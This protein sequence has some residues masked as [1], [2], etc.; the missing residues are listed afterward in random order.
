MAL[1]GRSCSRPPSHAPG[2]SLLHTVA[3]R[4]DEPAIVRPPRRGLRPLASFRGVARLT[5]AP[6]IA[7]TRIE[8]AVPMAR[9]TIDHVPRG[10]VWQ[11]VEAH[12][13]PPGGLLRV[14][15]RRPVAAA[16]LGMTRRKPGPAALLIDVA[17]I[18][19][20]GRRDRPP[21]TPAAHP[22]RPHFA[23]P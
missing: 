10:R 3:G 11:A 16:V 19:L 17:E 12:P 2:A 8:A 13:R 5:E 21:A 22:T 20:G 1:R 9:P 23:H 7:T 14:R 15:N 6:A 4:Q 18:P